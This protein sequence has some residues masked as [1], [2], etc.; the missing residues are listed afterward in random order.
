MRM[1]MVSLVVFLQE[2]HLHS[3]EFRRRK[4][5]FLF[6]LGK[7]V[8]REGGAFVYLMTWRATESGEGCW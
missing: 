6:Y 2:I 3:C 7:C 1:M 8:M 5:E 4:F